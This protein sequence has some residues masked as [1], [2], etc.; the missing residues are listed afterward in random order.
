MISKFA[1]EVQKE[2]ILSEEQEQ[3]TVIAWIVRQHPWLKD[4]TMHIANER[5]TS[6]RAGL[7]L[8]KMGVLKG[9]SDIFI[10]LPTQKYHGLWIEMKTMKGKASPYQLAF[11]DR[12]NK[13]GY[14]AAVCNGADAAMNLIK[15]YIGNKL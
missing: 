10:A 9:A 6:P 7:K 8:K 11:I 14:Y 1:S 3:I 4:Y 15:A 13:A 12:M 2:I 5:K